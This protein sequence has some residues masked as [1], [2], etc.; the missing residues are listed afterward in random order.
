MTGLAKTEAMSIS[1]IA[2]TKVTRTWLALTATTSVGALMKSVTMNDG[3]IF[4]AKTRW[5][6]N[7]TA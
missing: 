5:I 6:E 7:T 4:S 2:C 3:A 1:G